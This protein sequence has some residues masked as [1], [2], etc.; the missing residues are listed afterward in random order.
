MSPFPI[1]WAPSRRTGLTKTQTA[2]IVLVVI[3]FIVAVASYFLLIP[4]G[5]EKIV[6]GAVGPL[7]PPGSAVAGKEMKMALELAVEEV[8][9]NGGVLGKPVELI[10][11]DS[12][13]LPE[14][15][16]AAVEKLIT[17]DRVVGIVGEFH[18]SACL[19]EIEVT[20]RYHIPFII[21]DAWANDLTAKGYKEVFRVGPSNLI[22][23]DNIVDFIKG[24]G[25]KRIA[26]IVED[27]DFGFENQKILK[28][29]LPKNIEIVGE[30]V[31]DRTAKDFTPQLLKLKTEPPPD[32]I[33]NIMTGVGVYLSVKQAHDIGLCPTPETL[34]FHA[35][36]DAAYWKEYWETTGEAG[37]YGIY[38]TTY[39]AKAVFSEKTLPFVQRFKE[40]YGRDPTYVALQS[41]DAIMVLIDAIKR[42]GSTDPD[43][44]ITALEKTDF[45]GTRGR[46]TFM[47][48]EKDPSYY[49]QY[50]TRFLFIQYQ[51]VGQPDSEAEIVFPKELATSGIKYPPS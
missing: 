27:T 45:L 42:A 32:L 39:H 16:A 22:F 23:I 51:K 8:N 40:K 24:M 28:S 13:G 41:Y 43:A 34:M 15:G 1:F 48:A 19:A 6:I 46:I 20:H 26:L 30:V 29:R 5:P 35:G 47:T 12:S 7:T 17:K 3:L 9:K 37:L 21:V 33:V 31:V 11:E 44:L 14:K 50:Y 4:S 10:F 49:H 2:L 25:F 38:Q 18:S 36:G